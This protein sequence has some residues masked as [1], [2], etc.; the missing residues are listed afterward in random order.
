MCYNSITVLADCSNSSA[1]PSMCPWSS[2]SCLQITG[3]RQSWFYYTSKIVRHPRWQ[4]LGL[5][6]DG[7]KNYLCHGTWW[8]DA[9]GMMCMHA[10]ALCVCVHAARLHNIIWDACGMMYMHARQTWLFLQS[11]NG[12]YFWRRVAGLFSNFWE[13]RHW[14]NSCWCFTLPTRPPS[15][16]WREAQKESWLIE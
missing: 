8:D 4:S 2:S 5:R 10:K 1:S 6:T 11:R 12:R 13:K 16:A 15:A 14:E 9:C 3:T 7:G